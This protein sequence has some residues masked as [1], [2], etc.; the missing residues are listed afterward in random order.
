MTFIRSQARKRPPPDESTLLAWSFD[1]SQ[2]PFSSDGSASPAMAIGAGGSN[3]FPSQAGSV[4]DA[5]LFRGDLGAAYLTG[6]SG[7]ANRPSS[8]TALT[9]DI[10]VYPVFNSGIQLIAYRQYGATFVSPFSSA[11]MYLD[12]GVFRFGVTVSGTSDQP[13]S[14][15][16]NRVP[17][18]QFSHIGMTYDGANVRQYINGSLT[19]TYA[20]TGNVDYG[21][22]GPWIVGANSDSS[23]PFQGRINDLRVSTVVRPD[24]YF[25]SMFK[26]Y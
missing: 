9:I 17:E 1:G 8:L 3:V 24:D 26:S 15:N 5:V 16:S 23:S 6:G 12:A 22:D 14:I 18:G 20:R 7:S 19:R 25:K 21:T 4:S 2:A 10:W 13:A 11:A